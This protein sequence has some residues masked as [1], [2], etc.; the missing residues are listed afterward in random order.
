MPL[1]REPALRA[2]A[3]SPGQVRAALGTIDAV[4]PRARVAG[5][6]RSQVLCSRAIMPRLHCLALIY[7]LPPAD[8]GLGVV[9]LRPR[10]A[11]L[12]LVH[13]TARIRG[14]IQWTKTRS[15]LGCN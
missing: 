14:L 4:K 11:R 1:S 3:C 9:G 13:A 15:M 7:M 8:A 5:D 12:A 2:T 6:S 10:A